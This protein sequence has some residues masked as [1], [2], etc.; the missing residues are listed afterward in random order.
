M[1]TNRLVA[2]AFALG[3]SLAEVWPAEQNEPEKPVNIGSRLELF[4]DDFLIES[5]DGL[6][7]R[8]QSPR[9][10]G[11]VIIFDQPWEG[12]TSLYHTVFKDGDGFRLY[13]RGSSHQEYV[14]KSQ[15]RPEEE[16]VPVHESV[17]CLLESRDGIEWTRPSLGLVEFQGSTDNN[18]VWKGMASCCFAPFKDSNPDAPAEERYKALGNAGSGW[19]NHVL[20]AFVSDDGK[21]WRLASDEAAISD[22]K[23]DSL[24]VPFWDPVRSQYAAVYRDSDGVRS[25]KYATSKDFRNWT[26]GTWADYGGTPREHLYTNGT[27]PYFRAPHIFIALPKRFVPWRTYHP[28]ISIA[29]VSEAVFMSSRDGVHW[30]RRFMEAFIR[31]GRDPRNWV[32]RSNMPSAGV[33]PTSDDEMSLYVARHYTF[34]SAHLE[35][36]VLRTDGFVSI[37]A[38]YGEGEWVSRPLLFEGGNLVL[39]FATSAAGGIR[40][41]VQDA[42]GR[43]LPGFALEESPLIW[44]DEIEHTVRW[45]RS[46]LQAVSEKPLSRIA[47]KPV[48]LRFVM[49]DADLY[50]LRFR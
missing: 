11:K 1:R 9:S 37:H 14:D 5:M 34:P 30:D 6:E 3:L 21:R 23:F 44:G 16:I 19:P 38:G 48:R 36:M 8:L 17:T 40:L 12:T 32:H 13:Y 39:N 45:E 20:K 29:G 35:R 50:S 2:V 10:A 18:I 4:V 28:T 31:P 15:L 47:G 41:E 24:N 25:V 42:A 7:L 49:K 43:P 33:V 26:P 46:H 22:G 27:H